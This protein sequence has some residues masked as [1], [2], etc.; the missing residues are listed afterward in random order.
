MAAL[1]LACEAW[2]RHASPAAWQTIVLTALCFSQ[3]GHALAIRSERVS[4]FTLGLRSN[5]PLLGAVILTILLQLAI[6][7]VPALNVVFKTVPLDAGQL[8]ICVAVAA[9]VF[10]AVEIEKWTRRRMAAP[11]YIGAST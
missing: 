11:A 9:V 2:Y 3:L 6:V 5:M 4:L 10:G 1:V 7:Y 8:G